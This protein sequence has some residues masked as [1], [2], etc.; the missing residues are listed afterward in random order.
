MK[1]VET[2]IFLISLVIINHIHSNKDYNFCTSQN[3]LLDLN[4][5]YNQGKSI[6]IS[7]DNNNST[8]IVLNIYTST[9]VNFKLSIYTSN[10]TII[11]YLNSGNFFIGIDF[12]SNTLVNIIK[13]YTQTYKFF[14][15]ENNF[16]FDVIKSDFPSESEFTEGDLIERDKNNNVIKYFKTVFDFANHGNKNVKSEIIVCWL[17]SNLENVQIQSDKQSSQ[18]KICYD[19][20][21][22][23]SNKYRI[24]NVKSKIIFI[25]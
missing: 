23:L 14:S 9:E 25:D 17:N 20:E 11:Q 18:S 21:K 4:Y 2:L 24:S 5:R 22:D 12:D 19:Y 8:M 15:D 13:N 7:L 3:P 10:N 6:F 16:Y 1:L